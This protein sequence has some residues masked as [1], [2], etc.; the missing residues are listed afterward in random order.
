MS[1]TES[2]GIMNEKV[3]S[4]GMGITLAMLTGAAVGAGVALLFAPCSGKETRAWLAHRTRALKQTTSSVYSQ[5]MGA[6]Q[7]AT[8][9]GG[10][11]GEGTGMAHDRAVQ[12][13]PPT[14]PMRG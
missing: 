3:Q 12:G 5:G 7:R 2:E 8:K 10:K 11:D 14:T 1:S 4:G 13:R 9:E 6:I